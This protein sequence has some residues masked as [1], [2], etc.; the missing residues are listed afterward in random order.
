MSNLWAKAWSGDE[1]Y[2]V[3]L[4]GRID[5][6][7]ERVVPS[8]T[9]HNWL[10]CPSATLLHAET[11]SEMEAARNGQEKIWFRVEMELKLEFLRFNSLNA[12]RLWTGSKP[13]M[14]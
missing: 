12:K 9:K 5:F 10:Q 7:R 13:K 8:R 4:N 11:K 14:S 3:L 6:S 2:F 1:S